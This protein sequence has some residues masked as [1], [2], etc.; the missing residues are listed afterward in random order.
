V[1][2]TTDAPPP[3][4]GVLPRVWRA[5]VRDVVTEAGGGRSVPCELA[6]RLVRMTA[7]TGRNC[8]QAADR[9]GGPARI[10]AR[11]I[12]ARVRPGKG[13]PPHRGPASRIEPLTALAAELPSRPAIHRGRFLGNPKAVGYC[14]AGPRRAKRQTAI[15]G[16]RWPLSAADPDRPPARRLTPGRTSPNLDRTPLGDTACVD[17]LF[18]VWMPHPTSGGRSSRLRGFRVTPQTRGDSRRRC[19]QPVFSAEEEPPSR[20]ALRRP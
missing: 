7:A 13:S 5:S 12:L 2:P 6:T 20:E 17:P 19:H 8:R 4:E 16:R 11:P 18:V 1:K 14:P 15:S 3:R 10:T 9:G